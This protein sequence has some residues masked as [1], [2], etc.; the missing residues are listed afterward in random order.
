MRG[1]ELKL[2][3]SDQAPELKEAVSAIGATHRL[4][5]PGM[6]KTN[7]LIE[8]KVKLVL[9]GARVLLRQAGFEPRWWP[10]AVRHFAMAR[11]IENRGSGSP[12]NRRHGDGNFNG[13][14]LPF[15]CLVD[16]YP[17][18]PKVRRDR[19]GGVQNGIRNVKKAEDEDKDEGGDHW[20]INEDEGVIT[21]V[22]V[23]VRTQLFVP[24]GEDC[25]VRIRDLGQS[26]STIIN[27]LD[28]ST[29]YVVD[30][31]W[32]QAERN[33]ED[34][35]EWT[36]ETHFEC[37]F[38]RMGED[39]AEI[40]DEEEYEPEDGD[41]TE[42][43]LEN[44]AP[45]EETSVTTALPAE[46]RERAFVKIEEAPKFAPSSKPGLFLGYRLEPGGLWKGDYLVADLEHIQQ[47]LRKP[48]VHQVKR[49][50]KD[51][52]EPY[53]FPMLASYDARTRTIREALADRRADVEP[54]KRV[55]DEF[56][57]DE[58]RFDD[59]DDDD[60]DGRPDEGGGSPKSKEAASGDGDERVSD[61][62]ERHDEDNAWY[63]VH[64]DVRK[65]FFGATNEDLP[66]GGP[67]QEEIDTVRVTHMRG[68]DAVG[69]W[70]RDDRRPDAPNHRH[71]TRG[72][73]TGVTILFDKGCV[74]R[75]RFRPNGEGVGSSKD[76]KK[77]HKLHG[78]RVDYDQSAVRRER[79]YK[80][81]GKPNSIDADS[82]RQM[83]TRLRE[84][85]VQSERELSLRQERNR[86]HPDRDPAA[87]APGRKV[88]IEFACEPDSRLSAVMME[89]GGEAIRVHIGSFDITKA[90]DVGRLIEIIED[91]P[92][93]D[94]WASIPCGP[95]STW[96][97]V[98][99]S[100]YGAEFASHLNDLRRKSQVMFAAFMR[101]A[102]AVRRGGGRVAF[103]WPRHCLG[104]KQPFMQKFLADPDVETVDIDG[105]D[106]GMQDKVG[107]PIRKQW[108]IATTSKEL[109]EKLS[110]RK[111][112]HEKGYL[113]ARIEGSV[114]PTTALYPGPMCE[115]II[116]AWYPDGTHKKS[117][118]A[119]P[120]EVEPAKQRWRKKPDT[121]Y[122]SLDHEN[123]KIPTRAT[124]GSAGLDT[125]A[126]EGICIPAG[127]SGVVSAGISL[128]MP[129]GVYARIAPRS[130][131]AVKNRIAVGAGVIDPDYEGE[132]KVVLFNHGGEDFIV[133]P[134]D[135]IAQ[136][137]L[138]RVMM[139]DASIVPRKIMR[140]TERGS[141]GLG[142]TGIA[143]AA[144]TVG[145]DGRHFEF[146]MPRGEV[147]LSHR[148][149]HSSAYPPLY[150][151]VARPVNKKEV[152]TNAKAKA[153]LQKEWD[154]LASRDLPSVRE[155]SDVAAQAR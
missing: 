20:I 14:I 151:C 62:W 50:W 141:A 98:N 26:R 18:A 87:P 57:F 83:S 7:G 139:I 21:R 44:E 68:I 12:W 15:G 58:G 96:Q 5:T 108:R 70:V 136:I 66:P 53:A 19:K 73:W 109:I 152:A 45:I 61:Y 17:I 116:S 30:D 39:Q 40:F 112:K 128:E 35:G 46:R 27:Y 80:G 147:S 117:S 34:H 11:N 155:W 41:G 100:Q 133:Q 131:L 90:K 76:K 24:V 91:N 110:G 137:V 52:E 79:P 81:S 154:K 55:G 115:E 101:A 132:V 85:Y 59:Q 42:M 123:A 29:E 10:F 93:C 95:W 25:P 75:G 38:K 107:V 92:G 23:E 64:V 113:H 84:I 69:N 140:K 4:S 135:R 130:G 146:A 153:A 125:Y 144:P 104:W 1:Q 67:T 65:K 114:T 121:L 3:Y 97:Y 129:A 56:D 48:S 143:A 71:F 126:S 148:P 105:C 33:H 74:P 36:G 8:N 37:D 31:N 88:L 120:V 22:H 13:A 138:E 49:I 60:D 63:R 6:P 72:F 77:D 82:W 86:E 142:S 28:G 32:L 89:C 99:L 47:G 51:P 111:C 106:F 2:V 122:V 102:R 94:L 150:A 9:H 103:E 54:K 16:F 119:A 145:S 78:D 118:N 127:G 149:K 43:L 134:G 124:S